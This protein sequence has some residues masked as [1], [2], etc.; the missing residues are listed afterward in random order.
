MEV[1][2]CQIALMQYKLEIK[3]QET[4]LAKKTERKAEKKKKKLTVA[5]AGGD[6]SSARRWLITSTIL[7]Q[8]DSLFFD[9]LD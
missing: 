7:C 3:N 5:I 6:I 8:D 1:D 9:T 4:N 2:E